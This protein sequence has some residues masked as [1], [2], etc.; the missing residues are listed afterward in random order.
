MGGGG[1]GEG[2]IVDNRQVSYY[3]QY[4]C[5]PIITLNFAFIDISIFVII[6]YSV[7]AVPV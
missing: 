3:T 5:V 4:C 7:N 6:V 1:G 2:C